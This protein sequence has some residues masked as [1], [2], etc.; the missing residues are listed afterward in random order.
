MK[1]K[2]VVK[3]RKDVD[4]WIGI[5]NSFA[6]SMSEYDVALRQ[7]NR[8]THIERY[9]VKRKFKECDEIRR[10]KI[11]SGEGDAWITGVMVDAH[12]LANDYNVDPLTIVMCMNP[13]S[14]PNEKIL[15]K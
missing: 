15:V 13:L 3:S 2:I 1:N 10:K 14:K 11:P 9:T 6:K 12:L 4:A 7:Y 8:L 5:C